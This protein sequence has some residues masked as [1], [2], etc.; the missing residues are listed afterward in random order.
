MEMQQERDAAE[1]TYDATA[2]PFRRWAFGVAAGGVAGDVEGS[3]P[4]GQNAEVRSFSFSHEA[5]LCCP[6]D[7]QACVVPGICRGRRNAT[8]VGKPVGVQLPEIVVD[9]RFPV[10]VCPIYRT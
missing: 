5:C 2:N 6:Y 9:R 3:G 10:L 1:A 7:N 4:E 8:E